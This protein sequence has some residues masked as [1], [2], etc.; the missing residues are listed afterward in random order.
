MIL[1]LI[2]KKISAVQTQNIQN[3]S[4]FVLITGALVLSAVDPKEDAEDAQTT[5]PVHNAQCNFPIV[6]S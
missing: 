5:V 3:L 4:D 1:I 2:L 6:M